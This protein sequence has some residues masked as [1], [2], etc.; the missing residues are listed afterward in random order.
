[1]NMADNDKLVEWLEDRLDQAD[2]PRSDFLKMA[3]HAHYLFNNDLERWVPGTEEA[4]DTNDGHPV[5]TD[6]MIQPMLLDAVSLLL[7]NYPMF[8][9][10]PT[11]PTDFDLADEINK[12]VLSAWREGQVQRKLTISQLTA[13]MM[14]MSVIEVTP[15]WNAMAYSYLKQ[16]QY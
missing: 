3:A 12:H 4:V 1:M 14:G 16:L 2:G 8:R 7:K 13:L 6:N 11:K 15:S 10:K 5:S 9:I